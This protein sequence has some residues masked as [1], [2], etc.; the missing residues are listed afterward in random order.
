M[1]QQSR[2][3]PA[4]PCPVRDGPPVKKIVFRGFGQREGSCCYRVVVA[5]VLLVTLPGDG[6]AVGPVPPM[7]N[8]PI[9]VRPSDW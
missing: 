8:T 1:V 3:G 4:G 9:W 6:R 7:M 5:A 2:I